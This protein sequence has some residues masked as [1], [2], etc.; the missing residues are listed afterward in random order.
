M[1]KKILVGFTLL[2]CNLLFAIEEQVVVTYV[3]SGLKNSTNYYLMG[4]NKS[5]RVNIKGVKESSLKK[6]QLEVDMDTIADFGWNT[7]VDF[8]NFNGAFTYGGDADK[9]YVLIPVKKNISTNRLVKGNFS[10][11]EIVKNMRTGEDIKNIH[12]DKTF[13][14]PVKG[15][16]IIE[17]TNYSEGNRFIYNEN[18]QVV[19]KHLEIYKKQEY[20]VR[21][22]R[23]SM[24]MQYDVYNKVNPV[25]LASNVTNSNDEC[26]IE[27]LKGKKN[28][29]DFRFNGDNLDKVTEVRTNYG[30]GMSF[31]PGKIELFGLPRGLYTL[32]VYSFRYSTEESNRGSLVI[33]LEDT[34]RFEG[35]GIKRNEGISLLNFYP[36]RAPESIEAT[37]ITVSSS[38][39]S[40]ISIKEELESNVKVEVSGV[41]VSQEELEMVYTSNGKIVLDTNGFDWRS[42]KYYKKWKIKYKS[43]ITEKLERDRKVFYILN[44][45]VENAATANYK[46]NYRLPPIIDYPYQ[47]V[48]ATFNPSMDWGNGKYE[49]K[50]RVL[51]K[52]TFGY[53]EIKM[54][55]TTDV[56]AFFRGEFL[57]EF[58]LKQDYQDYLWDG[59]NRKATNGVIFK[60]PISD[61]KG[62][63]V[64]HNLNSDLGESKFTY[65]TTKSISNLIYQEEMDMGEPGDRATFKWENDLSNSHGAV[66]NEDKV[67][68][69]IVRLEEKTNQNGDI[70]S[71]ENPTKFYIYDVGESKYRI[72]LPIEYYDC[73]E[74]INIIS[75]EDELDRIN[76]FVEG[77]NKYVDLVFKSGI[78]RE[79]EGGNAVFTY[80]K[81]GTFQVIGLPRGSY[82][83]QIYSLQDADLKSKS[84]DNYDYKVLTYGGFKKFKMGLPSVVTGEFANKNNLFMID[85]I[86][87]NSDFDLVNNKPVKKVVVNFVTK[88][89]QKLDLSKDNLVARLDEYGGAKAIRGHQVGEEWGTDIWNKKLLPV[90]DPQ[91]SKSNKADFQFPLDVLFLIDNSGSMQN[92]IDSVKVGL[93]Q[94]TKQLEERGF[95]VKYNLITFGPPQDSK[96]IGDDWNKKVLK[97]DKFENHYFMALYK[98]DSVNPWFESVAELE[99]AFGK[100]VAGSGYYK[101]EEN[102]AWAIK[103]GKDYLVENGRFLDFNNNIVKN[104]DKRKGYIPSAKWMILL[105]DENMD[106]ENLP[107]GYVGN[108]VIKDLAK[109]LTDNSIKMTGII[110]TNTFVYNRM[111][112]DE[113]FRRVANLR[114]N[115]HYY[116]YEIEFK[117]RLWN[118][119][120]RPADMDDKFYMEF[121]LHQRIGEQL[122]TFYEMGETG[123]FV[124]SALSDAVGN[125]GIVQRWVMNYESPFPESDGFERQVIFSLKDILSI[126]KRKDENSPSPNLFIEPFMKSKKDRYYRVPEWKIEAYFLNPNPNTFEIIAKDEKIILKTRVKSQYKNERGDIVN[127]QVSNASFTLDGKSK[128]VFTYK[129]VVSGK[130]FEREEINEGGVRWYEFTK[131]I[132]KTYF[133]STFGKEE[134][135]VEFTASTDKNVSVK[136]YVTSLKLIEKNPPKIKSITLTNNSLKKT[137]E[138]LKPYHDASGNIE[139]TDRFITSSSSITINASTNGAINMTEID[140]LNVKAEDEIEVSIV[141]EEEK[142]IDF[143]SA[144]GTAISLAGLILDD[145]SVTAGADMEKRITGR[146]RLPRLLAL[147]NK[148]LLMNIVDVGGN[149]NEK[150][151]SNV[152]VVP[153]T[154]RRTM[155][156]DSNGIKGYENYYSGAED[157][158]LLTVRVEDREKSDERFL[159]YLF[160]FNH[161]RNQSDR[162]DINTYISIPEGGNKMLIPSTDASFVLMDGKYEYSAIFVMNRAGAIQEI[163]TYSTLSDLSMKAM[164]ERDRKELWV[165]TVSPE[166][167]WAKI[168]KREEGN[169]ATVE[170]LNNANYGTTIIDENYYK[171]NDIVKY[172]IKLNEFNWFRGSIEGVDINTSNSEK[173]GIICETNGIRVVRALSNTINIKDKAGNVANNVPITG[174]YQD[175]NPG[176]LFID[177]MELPVEDSNS[178]IYMKFIRGE[179]EVNVSTNSIKPVLGIANTKYVANENFTRLTAYEKDSIPLSSALV[180]GRQNITFISFTSAGSITINSEEIVVDRSINDTEDKFY[181]ESLYSAKGQYEVEIDFGQI[182]ELSGLESFDLHDRTV[183]V[184]PNRVLTIA[185]GKSKSSVGKFNYAN[186]PK[187]KFSNSTM[188]NKVI[189]V[190]VKDK[191]GNEKNIEIIIVINPNIKIIGKSTKANKEESSI[192]EIGTDNINIRN[193]SQD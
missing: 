136:I 3:E 139:I 113:Y 70:I 89:E 189:N 126:R 143:N 5:D 19:K 26:V 94:M 125:I 132:D 52:Q 66:I 128:K 164:Y 100:I 124:G 82:I 138:S 166:V 163:E 80:S 23:G 158:A 102:G 191:L 76:K 104:L 81:E 149:R 130:K 108:S 173:D 60:K 35:K 62:T 157:K 75:D 84:D 142:E 98:H 85:S 83:I 112:A 12:I 160:V 181:Y 15:I 153:K 77:T 147:T 146:V 148:N 144:T 68:F 134:L 91:L 93:K 92:E 177:G 154:K 17:D 172:S 133:E 168:V 99:G 109:E 1:M 117:D 48:M 67:I 162:S 137:L 174:I 44:S 96:S 161:D 90:I 56:D 72:E 30:L 176:S 165:D 131:E 16:D 6:D 169:R 150:V 78:D 152:L 43:N 87:V 171:D 155:F 10:M 42:N 122:F 193:K 118:G 95:D 185:N 97:Y 115:T 14:L 18:Y 34:M 156:N 73:Y 33:T 64:T 79:I 183:T 111:V 186:N 9:K 180:D 57:D 21:I 190:K 106:A 58:T 59:G 8:I 41:E 29:I 51:P 39:T 178:N 50:D 74:K 25:Q 101:S 53:K 45:N 36:G 116:P 123:E 187:F 13:Y 2:F 188:A 69:R 63:L 151:V 119:G 140:K 38:P 47:T 182:K 46:V 86:N 129:D 107:S 54:V 167:E 159:L 22:T 88:A 135:T 61:S 175:G 103:Y 179:E 184:I 7:S 71:I 37:V 65:Y 31:I 24:P 192:V 40:V 105:T 145:I 141:V 20:L 27:F 32:E 127:Y 170:A 28:Y 110:H 49:I 114:I 55:T 4:V 11:I 120:V 121:L